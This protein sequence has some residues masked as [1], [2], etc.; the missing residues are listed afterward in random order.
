MCSH[1]LHGRK[2]D[3]AREAEERHTDV[4]Q[5]KPGA[6]AATAKC[7]CVLCFMLQGKC[8]RCPRRNAKGRGVAHANRLSEKEESE[9]H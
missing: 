8:R 2:G 4:V 5:G 6:T 3:S 9:R 1:V 7:V